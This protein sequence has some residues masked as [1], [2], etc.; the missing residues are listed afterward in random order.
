MSTLILDPVA[1]AHFERANNLTLTQAERLKIMSEGSAIIIRGNLRFIARIATI[2]F[3]LDLV[4]KDFEQ[5]S[6]WDYL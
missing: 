4:E 2:R 5:P 1:V 3:P 6:P